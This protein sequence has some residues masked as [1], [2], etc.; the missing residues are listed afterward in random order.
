MNNRNL[1]CMFQ[2]DLL[3]LSKGH[4]CNDIMHNVTHIA[5]GMSIFIDTQRSLT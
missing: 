1:A 5:W 3:N 2:T 4:T